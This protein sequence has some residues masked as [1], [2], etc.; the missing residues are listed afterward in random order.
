MLSSRHLRCFDLKDKRRLPSVV[1]VAWRSFF[2]IIFLEVLLRVASVNRALFF[3]WSSA[4]RCNKHKK[5][6]YEWARGAAYSYWAEMHLYFK[7]MVAILREVTSYFSLSRG[8][9]AGD[10]S[11]KDPQKAKMAA[12]RKDCFSSDHT[13]STL[14][15]GRFLQLRLCD[16][17]GACCLLLCRTFTFQRFRTAVWWLMSFNCLCTLALLLVVNNCV[18][19]YPACAISD[20]CFA[21]I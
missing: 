9:S 11:Y 20:H 5:G 12:G 17:A 18:S 2:E 13:A 7:K 21:F 14:S 19:K 1:F 3:D 8:F 16:A 6:K 15:I 10:T 4:P